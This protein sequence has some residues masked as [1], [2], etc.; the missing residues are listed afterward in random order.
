MNGNTRFWKHSLV[1]LKFSAIVSNAEL[2]EL[3]TETLNNVPLLNIENKHIRILQNI[4]NIIL[5][6]LL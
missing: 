1:L 3:I 6:V 2:L 4:L 5:N